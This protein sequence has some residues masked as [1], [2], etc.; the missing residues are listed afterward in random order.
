MPRQVSG[1]VA[2][3]RPLHDS[4]VRLIGT[5][6]RAVPDLGAVTDLDEISEW[7]GTYRDRLRLA[8]PEE[9]PELT[10]HVRRWSDRLQQ[11]RAE[12]A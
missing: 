12:L 1:G 11:R 10:S 4:T 9:Q 6:P 2:N 5:V 7:L 8:H 3:D